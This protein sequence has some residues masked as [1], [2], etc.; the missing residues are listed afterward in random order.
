MLH[1][2]L[3]RFLLEGQYGPL[4]RRADWLLSLSITVGFSPLA[5]FLTRPSSRRDARTT[6]TPSPTPPLSH[7]P[8]LHR[9]QNPCPAEPHFNIEAPIMPPALLT[10]WQRATCKHLSLAISA[11]PFFSGTLHGAVGFSDP[12]AFWLLSLFSF[13]V[14]LRALKLFRLYCS[15]RL[16]N[17]TKRI[18]FETFQRTREKKRS[19]R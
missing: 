13:H 4:S 15:I 5:T 1:S 16:F 11:S 14:R 9:L 17:I 10:S 18:L 6:S 19:S 7:L 3:S 8:P 2:I 12:L